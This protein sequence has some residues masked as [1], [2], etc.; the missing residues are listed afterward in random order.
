MNKLLFLNRLIFTVLFIG[1]LSSAISQT[2][3][4]GK[5]L[6]ASKTCAACHDRSM[7]KTLIGPGLAGVE[8]RWEKKED[9]YQWIRD[10]KKLLDA[11]H[12]YATQ[13]FE[14]FN[15]VPMTPNPALTDKEIASLLLYINSVAA[16]GDIASSGKA[17]PLALK[18][19]ELFQAK[20]CAACHDIKFKSVL[21]GPVLTGVTDRWENKKDL[22]EWIKNPQKLLDAKHPYAT[23][24]FEKFNKVPMT[25]NPAITDEEIDAILAFIANPPSEEPATASGSDNPYLELIS[26]S[27]AAQKDS[28]SFF[29]SLTFFI[30][31]FVI[32]LCITLWLALIVARARV[33]AFKDEFG[34]EK[35]V[36]ILAVLFANRTVLKFAI[37]GFVIFGTYYTALR[38][39]ALGRQQDYQPDQPII[40]SHKVHAG[41]NKIDCSFCHDAARRSKHAMIPPTSTCMKCHLG[42]KTG[43]LYGT[44]EI[45]KIFVSIGFNP[46][47]NQYIENYDKMSNEEIKKIFIEWIKTEN[48]N[49]AQIAEEQWTNIMTSLTSDIKPNVSGPIPWTRIHNLPDHVYFNHAQHFTV[50]KIQCQSCHGPV[51]EMEVVKQF[52]PLSMGWCVNCHRETDVKFT[53]NKYYDQY[54]AK[55]HE[56][57]KNGFRA[58][59]KVKDIGGLDCQKCHY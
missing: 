41:D 17:D 8:S 14:K 57:M 36:N 27:V 56:E 11:K 19:K 47:T 12:P 7:T 54:F 43:T 38:G 23:Q 48:K 4:E 6:F 29:T 31:L 40:Y 51:Q 18:G 39:I 1:F 13:L 9:L 28:G 53:E 10:S 33:T 52:A 20:A 59:V 58:G 42:I 55:Y 15:K 37:F 25:P 46:V 44:R 2:A 45:A 26:P 35:S 22:Y 21:V 30:I 49:D 32:L 3:D 24:L 50:G 34:E 16:G 5:E